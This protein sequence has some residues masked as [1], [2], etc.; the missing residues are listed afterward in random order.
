[1]LTL[2]PNTQLSKTVMSAMASTAL[3][4]SEDVVRRTNPV[5]IDIFTRI[6]NGE[7]THEEE[8]AMLFSNYRK[9]RKIDG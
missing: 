9:Y 8:I 6:E 3:E 5:L 2:P 1:M 7:S 4:F